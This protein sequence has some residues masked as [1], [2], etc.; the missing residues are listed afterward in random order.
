MG[1]ISKQ[2][3]RQ[4]RHT[5]G[6]EKMLNITDYQINANQNYN[7]VSP[8][9]SQNGQYQKVYKPEELRIVWR[10]RNPPTLFLWRTVWRFLKKLK[11]S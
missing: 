7:E 5:D 9:I 8:H 2:T 6:Q 10:N 4:R 1:R 3:F 11:N